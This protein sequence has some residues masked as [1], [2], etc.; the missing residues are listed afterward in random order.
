[1]MLKRDDFRRIVWIVMLI[2]SVSIPRQAASA[3]LPVPD[4]LP[5]R[6]IN[7][8]ILLYHHI[9]VAAQPRFESYTISPGDFEQQMRLLKAWGYTSVSL[10][11]LVAALLDDTPLP[12]RPV[13]ITF[14]DGYQ[15]VY[16][17]ALPIL[18]ELDFSATVFVIGRQ[19]GTKGYMDTSELKELVDQGWQIGNH[20]YNHYS[21]RTR[22][23]DLTQEIETA[24]QDLEDGLGV[25]VLYFSFPY[26]LTSSYV[27]RQVEKAGYLAAVGLGGSYVHSK[28]TRFYLSRIEIKPGMSALEFIGLLPWADPPGGWDA[29]GLL[30]Q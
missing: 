6:R 16:A 22:G 4:P 24:R 23:I 3:S 26:G 18:A 15:D 2:F 25:S 7:V 17:H 14:D 19:V 20:T 29:M 13:V 27:T 10:A 11:D 1:M 9:G 5:A 12:Y 8:P 28:A 21:L 30:A